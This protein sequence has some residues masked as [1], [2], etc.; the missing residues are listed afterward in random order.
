MAR[1][2]Q[3]ARKTAKG[4]A[5]PQPPLSTSHSEGLSSS[6]SSSGQAA[7]NRQDRDAAPPLTVQE[8]RTLLLSELSSVG[9]NLKTFAAFLR[10]HTMTPVGRQGAG[11]LNDTDLQ[12]CMTAMNTPKLIKHAIY[13]LRKVLQ[14]SS[15]QYRAK[16]MQGMA[17]PSPYPLLSDPTQL[18]F[19]TTWDMKVGILQRE[20]L[21][22]AGHSFTPRNL[23]H[24]LAQA[25]EE[26]RIKH[27]AYKKKSNAEK[28]SR[29]AAEAADHFGLKARPAKQAKSSAES[30]VSTALSGLDEE[31]SVLVQKS[32][33]AKPAQ[34]SGEKA[35]L[36]PQ[37]S[38]HSKKSGAAGK[39]KESRPATPGATTAKPQ[40]PEPA[41]PRLILQ[42][43]DLQVALQV[44]A[45]QAPLSPSAEAV[46]S[47]G[48]ALS[49]QAA[50]A[51]PPSP[52]KKSNAAEAPLQKEKRKRESET[53][54]AA[55]KKLETDFNQG[56]SSDSDSSSSSDISDSDGSAVSSV[57]GMA[58]EAKHGGNA[59]RHIP[60]SKP[61]QRRSASRAAPAVSQRPEK[62]VWQ[63]G[64]IVGNSAE[65]QHECE[66]FAEVAQGELELGKMRRERELAEAKQVHL[67]L[68]EANQ[69]D[70][71]RKAFEVLKMRNALEAEKRAYIDSEN[72]D[73]QSASDHMSEDMELFHQR[74][75]LRAKK[76]FE[77]TQDF[78][79]QRQVRESQK[80]SAHAKKKKKKELFN[81]AAAAA[82]KPVAKKAVPRHA[83]TVSSEGTG[84][85]CS[86]LSLPGKPFLPCKFKWVELDAKQQA[87]AIMLGYI[88]SSHY[89]W[90]ACREA[91]LEGQARCP[92]AFAN[93]TLDKCTQLQRMG[94]KTLKIYSPAFQ[95]LSANG[96]I[97][98]YDRKWVHLS[99]RHRQCAQILGVNLPGQKETK[100]WDVLD[101]KGEAPAWKQFASFH[102]KFSRQSPEIKEA[103]LA[104]HWT[105]E[106]WNKLVKN[107]RA[108]ISQE[109]QE[110]SKHRLLSQMKTESDTEESSASQSDISIEDSDDSDHI[111]DDDAAVTASDS[112]SSNSWVEKS[113]KAKRKAKDGLLNEGAA[114]GEPISAPTKP[115]KAK[116]EKKA[117]ATTASDEL[118]EGEIE[119]IPV[120]K[121]KLP[122]AMSSASSTL[123][124][125]DFAGKADRKTRDAFHLAIQSKAGMGLTMPSIMRTVVSPELRTPIFM[126]ALQTR[127]RSLNEVF[128]VHTNHPD[129]MPKRVSEVKL[130]SKEF[131]WQLK[132]WIPVPNKYMQALMAAGFYP[133]GQAGSF[134]STRVPDTAAAEA[135]AEAATFTLARQLDLAIDTRQICMM[136][137][138]IT[139]SQ[140]YVEPAQIG[141]FMEYNFWLK[142]LSGEYTLKAI[143]MVDDYLMGYRQIEQ[144]DFGD[145]AMARSTLRTFGEN[146]RLPMSLRRCLSCEQTGKSAYPNCCKNVSHN[147]IAQPSA[148][149]SSCRNKCALP[150]K[151]STTE[152]EIA[153]LTHNFVLPAGQGTPSKHAPPWTCRKN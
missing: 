3:T 42:E 39:A 146:L 153:K 35:A 59:R 41:G 10:S 130:Y 127:D 75:V 132:F 122:R 49:A 48:T 58:Q 143:L 36:A 40:S 145:L 4:A 94:A 13:K 116:K 18:G 135:T 43:A 106:T 26:H 133:G 119:D 71:D 51:P 20:K 128:L 38:P 52:W 115:K 82:A 25:T 47:A 8:S 112:M 66:N 77:E 72:M 120:I 125:S 123:S 56:S 134:A 114:G 50:A 137:N 54:A 151:T 149:L 98:Y 5:G 53:K 88:P 117:A 55:A 60:I 22:K 11:A 141:L 28:A 78:D 96:I 144:W 33:Q 142:T 6:M 74:K 24:M 108:N 68:T 9:L 138:V 85:E 81:Q 90:D 84:S 65:E 152:F 80:A 97:A 23:E 21:K 46:P 14:L 61:L 27:A 102:V 93:A 31:T 76:K 57:D 1:C 62:L 69:L 140:G 104:L 17:I 109:E 121:K 12:E 73:H 136:Q 147:V 79:Y 131:L 63:P 37:K 32:A 83:E 129:Y 7:A 99:P 45:A 148:P 124:K 101:A 113:A 100:K 126:N 70:L 118:E 91:Y 16:L 110:A 34:E 64:F 103:I 29:R 87:A 67:A 30:K 86:V 92:E 19:L 89:D 107:I 105:I 2:K 150:L 111:L 44:E 15:E 139:D 95:C